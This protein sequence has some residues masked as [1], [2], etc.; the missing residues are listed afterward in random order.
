MPQLLVGENMVLPPI[1]KHW[2]SLAQRGFWP[3]LAA[4]ALLAAAGLVPGLPDAVR[5]VIAAVAVLVPGLFG[6]YLWAGWRAATLTLTDQRVILEE[7]IVARSSMVIPLNRVQDVSTKQDALG[8]IMD[9]GSILI[10]AA[11]TGSTELFGYASHP[12]MLRDQVFLLSEQR[13]RPGG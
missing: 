9:Y 3:G 7:G 5:L 10:H 4:A 1:R 12:E 2:F 8:R 11:G 6:A 13:Q